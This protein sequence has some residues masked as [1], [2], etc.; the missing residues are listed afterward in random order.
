MIYMY[1]KVVY[2]KESILTQLVLSSEKLLL[3]A[4]QELAEERNFKMCL[5]NYIRE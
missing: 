4:L 5:G 3:V 1:K 2:K